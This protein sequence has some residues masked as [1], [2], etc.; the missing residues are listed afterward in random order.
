MDT[1]DKAILIQLLQNC[2]VSYDELGQRVGLSASSVWRRVTDLE[3]TGIID[4]YLLTLTPKVITPIVVQS[5]LTLDGTRSDE[6]VLDD[7]L[8]Q[9][10]LISLTSVINRFCMVSYEVRTDSERRQFQERL[11]EIPGVQSVDTYTYQD[12]VPEPPDP[13][14]LDFSEEQKEV[15]RLLVENPKI[16]INEIAER[17]DRPYRKV[18]KTLDEILETGTVR[19]SLDWNPNAKGNE[20]FIFRLVLES[21]ITTGEEVKELATWM[22]TK[23]PENFWWGYPMASGTCMFVNF[24]FDKIEAAIETK[25]QIAEHQDIQYAEMF[26]VIAHMKKPRLAERILQEYL[27][28]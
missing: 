19:W 23:Y 4:R 7:I 24:V 8:E 17:T 2:R 21:A 26:F 18:K 6:D 16:A 3:E 22:S 11:L 13:I 5:M 10:D 14:E 25:K 1:I 12:P 9:E 28:L 27:G 15:L 20:M